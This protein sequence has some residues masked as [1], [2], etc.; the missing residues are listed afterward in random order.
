MNSANA[1]GDGRTAVDR[2]SPRPWRGLALLTFPLIVLALDVSVLFLAAPALTS[3]LGAS[4]TQ[5]L[6]ITDIYGFCIAGFLIVMGVVGDRVG[7]RRLLVIGGL[8]FAG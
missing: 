7:R 1:P 4:P 8:A 3:D 5:V 2:S 6:W